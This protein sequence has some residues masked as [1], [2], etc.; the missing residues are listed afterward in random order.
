MHDDCYFLGSHYR[1]N[2]S[3]IC[4]ETMEVINREFNNGEFT[5]PL[6]QCLHS[7]I[8]IVCLHT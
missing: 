6:A 4:L 8:P 3:T 2:H 5:Y 7:T 1:D